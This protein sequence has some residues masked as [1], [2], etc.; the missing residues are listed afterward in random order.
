M[1]ASCGSPRLRIDEAEGPAAGAI[2]EAEELA[3]AAGGRGGTDDELT[4]LCFHCFQ[5]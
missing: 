4:V 1:S 5:E 3:A 2:D